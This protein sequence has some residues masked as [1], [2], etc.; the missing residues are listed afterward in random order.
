MKFTIYT[1]SEKIDKFYL[2]AIKEYEKR[3]SRYCT[4]KLVHLKREDQLEKKLNNN[5]YRLHLINNTE[6][7]I[8]SEE[9]ASKINGLG[10]SGISDI[11]IIIGSVT[12]PCDST[13]T[14][15]PMDMDS[16]LKTTI[17]FEQLYRAFRIINNHPYHK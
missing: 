2:E 5:S 3:L 1:I 10:V 12:A 7:S 11:S 8:S 17:L 6:H 9:L 16:G 14:L 4:V 15:S 13:L